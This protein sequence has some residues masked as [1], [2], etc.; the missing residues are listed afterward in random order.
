MYAGIERSPE[1]GVYFFTQQ[2]IDR[3]LDH[4]SLRYLQLKRGLAGAGAE[5]VGIVLR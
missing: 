1:Q 4:L 2:I 3:Y 5:G